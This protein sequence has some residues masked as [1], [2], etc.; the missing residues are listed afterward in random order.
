[1]KKIIVSLCW[2]LMQG[3]ILVGAVSLDDLKDTSR[4]LKLHSTAMITYYVDKQSPVVIR[5][6]PPYYIIQGKTVLVSYDNNTISEFTEKVY[7]DYDQQHM[8]S[9]TIY[10]TS[11]TF[12]GEYEGSLD[13]QNPYLFSDPVEMP[14]NSV[15]SAIGE[16]YF[17]LCYNMSFWK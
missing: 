15:G 12:K 4:Y 8:Q 14:H 16:L 10:Q 1:M 6:D 3:F 11:Y 17:Y 13:Y 7:Y 2:F 5:Y 9:Q